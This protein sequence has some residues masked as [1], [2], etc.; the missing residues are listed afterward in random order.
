MYGTQPEIQILE[1]FYYQPLFRALLCFAFSLVGAFLLTSWCAK[2]GNFIWKDVVTK[3]T[4]VIF[5]LLSQYFIMFQH[6]TDTLFTYPAFVLHFLAPFLPII[7]YCK[8]MLKTR[9]KIRNQQLKQCR[10]VF[11]VALKLFFLF[12][13]FYRILQ[14]LKDTHIYKSVIINL[15]KKIQIQIFSCINVLSFG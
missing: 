13:I 3:T 8:N 12:N 14:I 2:V 10:S 1:V 9:N 7:F 6:K 4:L 5:V 15:S 11:W